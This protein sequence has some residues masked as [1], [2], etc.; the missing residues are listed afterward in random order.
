MSPH[1]RQTLVSRR[2]WAAAFTRAVRTAAQTAVGLIGTAALIHE[3]PWEVVA[4]GSGL[5]AVVSLLTS[6]GGLPEIE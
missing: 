3:V 2:F 1:R 5:A 6:L 4:S